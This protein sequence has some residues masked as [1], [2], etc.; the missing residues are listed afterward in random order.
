MCNFSKWAT[1]LK[2]QLYLESVLVDVLN[3]FFEIMAQT[4]KFWIQT[5]SSRERPNFLESNGIIVNIF[6]SIYKFWN[7]SFHRKMVCLRGLTVEEI[8]E[9]Y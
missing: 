3:C 4:E 6:F 8:W 7:I 9:M 5:F 2:S 1:S